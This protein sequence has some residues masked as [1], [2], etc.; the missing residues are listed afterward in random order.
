[1]NG[2]LE[3][4]FEISYLCIL[5][6]TLNCAVLCVDSI[7]LQIIFLETVLVVLIFRYGQ[8]IF[9]GLDG[10]PELCRLYASLLGAR[11]CYHV[12]IDRVLALRGAY[13]VPRCLH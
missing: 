10:F 13:W 8:E 7:L 5:L 3:F 4:V 12:S 2:S 9:L 6:N 11:S 1:M